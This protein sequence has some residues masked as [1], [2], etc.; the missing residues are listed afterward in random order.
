MIEGLI[1]IVVAMVVIAAASDFVVVSLRSTNNNA[2][3]VS[4][5]DAVT[6]VLERV[7]RELRQATDVIGPTASG[8]K[9]TLHEYYSST[10]SP[11]ASLH[12]VTWDCANLDSAGHYYC[13]RTDN[14]AGTAAVTELTGLSSNNVFQSGSLPSGSPASYEPIS[15]TFSETVTGWSNPLVL[16]EMVTPRDCQYA[17]YNQACDQ[18]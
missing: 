9:L 11:P 12:S 2:N 15:V 17:G 10:G 5:N 18:G 3:R 13:T 1:A 16:T 6:R 14:T 8:A 7:T 4:G